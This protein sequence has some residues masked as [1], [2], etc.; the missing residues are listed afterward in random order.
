[1]K[2]EQA[3]A[4]L[5]TTLK[6]FEPGKTLKNYIAHAV[7]PKF[8]H[9]EAVPPAGDDWGVGIR[10]PGRLAAVLRESFELALLFRR[11]A[12][13]ELDAGVLANVDELE[14]TGPR[15]DFAALCE[16]IDAPALAQRADALAAKRT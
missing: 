9:I 15:A 3:I 11:I 2:D 12:T 14:W 5:V 6:G 8:K 1:M 7:F 16:S 4:A 13:L 10:N